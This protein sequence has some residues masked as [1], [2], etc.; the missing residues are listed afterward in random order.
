[1]KNKSTILFYINSIHDGG[2]ER[3]I[4]QLAYRFSLAGYR[5]V[6]VTSFVDK[7]FEYEVPSGVERISIEQDEIKQSRLKRN[8]S[9]IKALRKICKTYKPK[10]VVS[11]MGEPN[12]RNMCATVGLPLKKIISVRNDPN[13]EYSGRISRLVGKYLLPFADGCVFQTEDAKAW[14]SKRLQKKSAVIY[15]AVAEEFFETAYIGGKNVVTLGRLSQ[16][17]NQA[18]LIDAFSKIADKFPECNLEIYG[19]GILKDDLQQKII[20]LK[21]QDRIKLMGATNDSASVLANAKCFVLSSDYEGMPNALMEALTVG[22]PSIATD[23]PCGG[24][25]MLINSGENG[26]LTP[27]GD[28]T[29][30]AAALTE[31][32]GNQELAGKLSQNAKI[33]A[34]NFKPDIIF[35]KW[36]KYI[37]GIIN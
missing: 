21:M 19:E 22:V 17:K 29:A 7:N 12:F 27:V 11:F 2:A 15:N 34:Q 31:V 23:C 8:I 14:F 3:V 18:M 33:N 24:P 6:L 32:L 1:M 4:L 16:Q 28:T 10:A 35:E 30:L 5:S 13:R 9:R 26:L 20:D 25:K 36:Q 37:E